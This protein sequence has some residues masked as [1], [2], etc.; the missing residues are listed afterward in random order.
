MTE[1]VPVC[2]PVELSL[3]GSIEKGWDFPLSSLGG[4]HS[5]YY[6]TFVSSVVKLVAAAGGTRVRAD[7]VRSLVHELRCAAPEI[8][9][10]LN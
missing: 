8:N 1:L 2:S 5:N 3:L 9:F 4:I 7:T 10:P 6:N